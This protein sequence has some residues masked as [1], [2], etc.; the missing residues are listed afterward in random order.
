MRSISSGVHG[1]RADGRR[2]HFTAARFVA[3]GQLIPTRAKPRA[4]LRAVGR[5]RAM[6]HSPARFNV[7]KTVADVMPSSR[8]AACLLP[9]CFSTMRMTSSIRSVRRRSLA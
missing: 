9:P 7:A 3:S 6:G 4:R 2:P 5:D 1:V 8:A